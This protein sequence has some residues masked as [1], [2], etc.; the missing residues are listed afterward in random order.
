M[1]RFGV[2]KHLQGAR[3]GGP[4]DHAAARP[5]EAPLPQPR[6]DPAHP[7]P[8]GE[9]VRRALGGGAQ[10]AQDRTGGG[11]MR[12]PYTVIDG[13]ERCRVRDLHQDDA[14]AALGGDHRPEMRAQVQLRG[15][16][17]LRL[18]ARLA[19]TSAGAPGVG[20]R[21]P[22]ARTSRSTRRAGSCR[23]FTAL[24]SDE[25]KA[26]GDLAGDLGDRA[27]RRLLPADASPTTS[28]RGRQQRALRRL[29]DDPLRPQDAARDRRAARHARARCAT[30]ARAASSAVEAEPEP[31]ERPQPEPAPARRCGRRRRAGC[32]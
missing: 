28:C 32:G 26:E 4:G 18:D 3:G 27:G 20:S 16:D 8:L 12:R 6:P 11:L 30:P 24:W 7:R 9:Q 23:R 15:R 21:S 5:R 31:V 10:R 19:A 1:T 13:T 17:R 14:G 22:R 25:V 29:A 2:M